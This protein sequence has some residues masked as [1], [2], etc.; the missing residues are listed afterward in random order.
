MPAM[1]VTHV[2]HVT[3]G[4]SEHAWGDPPPPYAPPGDTPATLPAC[5]PPPYTSSDAMHA[6]D[7]ILRDLPPPYERPSIDWYLRQ[8]YPS[9]DV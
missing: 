3:R 7:P 4:R 2:T 5:A 9:A 6:G 8:G 1:H